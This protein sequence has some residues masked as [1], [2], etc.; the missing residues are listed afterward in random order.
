[1]LSSIQSARMSDPTLKASGRLVAINR[2]GIIVED[3]K[4]RKTTYMCCGRWTEFEAKKKSRLAGRKD[5]L[6]SDF[7]IG[8]KV[9]VYYDDLHKMV[10]KLRLL[11]GD[12]KPEAQ[13]QFQADAQ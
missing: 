2:T 10:I 11:Q 4:G 3:G 7:R 5:L 8:D 1:M 6:Y 12:F 9:D 13:Q